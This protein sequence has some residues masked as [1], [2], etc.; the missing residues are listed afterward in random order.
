MCS[1]QL[2]KKFLQG[3][4]RIKYDE[5]MRIVIDKYNDKLRRI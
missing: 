1:L 4:Q 2:M 3:I 5:I